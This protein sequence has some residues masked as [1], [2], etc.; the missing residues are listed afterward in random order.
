MSENNETNTT[1]ESKPGLYFH[2]SDGQVAP[3]RI[4]PSPRA[5]RRRRLTAAAA[6]LAA[7]G[8]GVGGYALH[9]S[10]VQQGKAEVRAQVF[11]AASKPAEPVPDPAAL[12]AAAPPDT[13][14]HL[15]RAI[16]R[17]E[18]FI[19]LA[20]N[21]QGRTCMTWVRQNDGQVFG[22]SG[23]GPYRGGLLPADR[24]IDIPQSKWAE[25]LQCTMP[26][27]WVNV[28]PTPASTLPR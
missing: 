21:G 3:T 14:M 18:P 20:H 8:G 25:T 11:A 17:R 12:L 23:K 4:A 19:F 2:T 26:D 1:A 15:E 6:V 28:A 24:L 16:Q 27:G 5:K 13:R 9:Q 22:F 10:G 7:L